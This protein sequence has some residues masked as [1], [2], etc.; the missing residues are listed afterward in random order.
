MK[1][2]KSILAVAL[3]VL[4]VVPTITFAKKS[5]DDYEWKTWRTRRS[6]AG[7]SGFGGFSY[8]MQPY[9]SPMLDNLATSMG[10][11]PL[12]ENLQGMG[13]W[14]MGHIGGGWRLGGMGYGAIA[15]TTGVFQDPNTNETYNRKITLEYGLGGFMIEYSP[16]M[17][18]PVNF[19]LGSTLGWGG[20]TIRLQQDAGA[21][22]WNDLTSQYIGSPSNG[23]NL[24]TEITQDFVF[25]EPYATARVHILDWMALSATVGYHF[26][27]LRASEWLFAENE[28]SGLGPGLDMN[29]VYFR[30]GMIFGG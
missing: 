3:I 14:G 16:W 25:A 21:F 2:W 13:G 15:K 29:N 30:V 11:D 20:V 7:F 19:G 12:D 22:T 5:D 17:I 9:S 8:T 23:E 1:K 18:G 4:L 28:L 10:L 6:H 26:D 27:N 24:T